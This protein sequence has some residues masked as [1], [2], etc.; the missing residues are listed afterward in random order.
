MKVKLDPGARLPQR[1][2]LADAGYDLYAKER[3]TV[4]AHGSAEFDTGVHIELPANV[5]GLIVSKSGLNINHGLT[6]EGLIDPGFTGSIRVK[7]YNN[8][9]T[10]YCVRKGDKISQ[11]LLVPFLTPDLEIVEELDDTERGSAGYGSTGR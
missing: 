8:T 6:S 5:A 9:D 7:L 4:P 10:D 11:L 1:A 2:H 3:N